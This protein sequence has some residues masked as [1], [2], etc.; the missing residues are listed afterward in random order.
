MQEEHQRRLR[1]RARRVPLIGILVVAAGLIAACGSSSSSTSASSGSSTSA[2]SGSTTSASASTSHEKVV[3]QSPVAA[4]PGQ[5]DI[6]YG[7]ALGAKELGWSSE[8][9]DA[10][11]SADRQV[12]NIETALNTGVNAMTSWSLDSNAVA[13]PYTRAGQKG[14]PVI[15]MMS[16]GQ[17]VVASIFQDAEW[18]NP[19]G[20]GADQV[21]EAQFIAKRYPGARVMVITFPAVQSIVGLTSCFTTAAKQAGLHIIDTATNS[22]D[23][24][25]ASE[26]IIAPLITKNPTVQAIWCYNDATALG[27]SA[28]LTAAKLKVATA[29]SKGG[30]IVIGHN[31]DADAIQAIRDGRLTMTWDVNNVATGLAA[32]RAMQDALQKKKPV[33]YT[34]ASTMYT[35]ANVA[36][37]KPPRGRGYTLQNIPVTTG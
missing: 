15:G 28:A 11:L 3:Y 35:S 8:V 34:V 16:T 33:N 18:C 6:Y 23:T 1:H 22:G 37:Y 5:Q 20:P 9:L 2:S 17:G 26:T 24:A 13:G 30:V 10:N 19:P 12:T 25:A 7:I 36:Q 29:T 32:V 4:E 21:Q 14:V 31:G 27:A